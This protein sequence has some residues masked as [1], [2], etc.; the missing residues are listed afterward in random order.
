MEQSTQSKSVQQTLPEIPQET[1]DKLILTPEAKAHYSQENE[2]KRLLIER[3]TYKRAYEEQQKKID[4]FANQW[5]NMMSTP[6]EV[7]RTTFYDMKGNERTSTNIVTMRDY[8]HQKAYEYRYRDL[9]KRMTF[10]EEISK[11]NFR[12]K[13][14]KNILN[15][16][17]Y[18]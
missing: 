13:Y 2:I 15:E 12:I 11:F 10:P 5:D 4:E 6:V 7:R 3:E 8:I 1:L 14:D 17:V 18:R 9:M 16:I